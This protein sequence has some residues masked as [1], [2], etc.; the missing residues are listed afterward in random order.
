M[1]AR[2]SRELALAPIGVSDNEASPD[3]RTLSLRARL[4]DPGLL[5]PGQVVRARLSTG[6]APLA[7]LV[8]DQ[9]VG[10][11]QGRRYVLVVN[12]RQAVEYRSV[13][14][15]AMHQ[16]LRIVRPKSGF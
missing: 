2:D 1:D 12:D 8:Q 13:T 9:A 14:V 15:G 3:T 7:L 16:D 11:D 6:A 10:T 5:M 4:D